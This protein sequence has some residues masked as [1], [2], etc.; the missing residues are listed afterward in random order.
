M[1]ITVRDA[2]IRQVRTSVFP[3]III[4]VPATFGDM[5]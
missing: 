4:P 1:Q 3:P 2:E 5:T